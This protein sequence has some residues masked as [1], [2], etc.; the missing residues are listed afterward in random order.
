MAVLASDYQLPEKCLDL[1]VF[2]DAGND[3][4]DQFALVYLFAHRQRFNLEA[5]YAEA[6]VCSGLNT[7]LETIEFSHRTIVELLALLGVEGEIAVLDGSARTYQNGDCDSLSAAELDFIRR[8]RAHSPESRLYVLAISAATS[9]AGALRAAPDIADSIYVL[10]VGGESFDWPD[11]RSYNAEIDYPAARCLLDAPLPLVLM[12]GSGVLDRFLTP[13]IEMKSALHLDRALDQYLWKTSL[14][15]ATASPFA[16][17][18]L[19]D[20]LGV[21]YFL[22]RPELK[23]R[24]ELRPIMLDSGFYAFDHRRSELLY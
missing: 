6:Y 12:P 2:S 11:N 19:Y 17:K 24:F 5:I 13:L 21:A 20:V 1:V 14:E 4:D 9:L 7:R 3:V 8:A 16:S 23:L 18:V 10:W 22:G 15:C